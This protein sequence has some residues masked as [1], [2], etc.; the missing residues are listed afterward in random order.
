MLKKFIKTLFGGSQTSGGADG[1]FLQV[2]CD[3]CG[4]AFRL[5]INKSTDLAQEFDEN[6]NAYYKL[7]KEIIGANCRNLIRVEM[8]FDGAKRLVSKQIENGSYID[9]T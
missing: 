8:I 5:F 6:E 7:K 9:K 2:R 3:Q 1:F 4:E